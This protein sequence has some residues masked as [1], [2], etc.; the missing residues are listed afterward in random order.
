MTDS[1]RASAEFEASIEPS[2]TITV[3]PDIAREFG[4]RG[5]TLHVTLTANAISAG[6]K[7]REVNEEEIERIGA[8]QLESREQVVK[9][10]MSEGALLRR[11]VGRKRKHY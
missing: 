2:G 5:R 4:K 7:D 9:F 1:H 8:I 11:S 3:P 6:L 10:L